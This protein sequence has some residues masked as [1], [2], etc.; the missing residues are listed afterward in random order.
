MATSLESI[1]Q[2]SSYV[3]LTSDNTQHNSELTSDNDSS[4]R[5]ANF[6][7]NKDTQVNKLVQDATKSDCEFASNN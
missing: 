6:I 1:N 7:L 2:V 3:D 5:Q 4:S